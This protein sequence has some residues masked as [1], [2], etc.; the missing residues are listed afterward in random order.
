VIPVAHRYVLGGEGSWDYIVRAMAVAGS[1]PP[2]CTSS[3][4][5]ALLIDNDNQHFDRRRLLI[6]S[7]LP[8][9]NRCKPASHHFRVADHSKIDLQSELYVALTLRAVDQTEKGAQADDR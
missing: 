1:F 5:L 9:T 4:K 6:T 3:S 8:I 2:E 7:R